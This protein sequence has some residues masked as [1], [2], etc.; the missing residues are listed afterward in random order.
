LFEAYRIAKARHDVT[1]E[2]LKQAA[3]WREPPDADL[4]K[5][6]AEAA[7]EEIDALIAVRG[8]LS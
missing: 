3:R 6:Q 2:A 5:R 7:C 1:I 4:V 8:A